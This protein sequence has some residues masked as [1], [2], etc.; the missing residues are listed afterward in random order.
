M[1]RSP[2][3]T[4]PGALHHVISR[5]V[6]RRWYL[7]ADREREKYLNLLG[8]ALSQTDWRCIAYCLMSNHLHL[9]MVAG[10]R[11]LDSWVRKVNSPFA[12]WLNAEHDRLGPVFA[13]R[14]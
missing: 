13:N 12:H 4:T 6:D 2:R 1:P 5:F 3:R 11:S 9:A 10:E 7:S 14:P 8:R